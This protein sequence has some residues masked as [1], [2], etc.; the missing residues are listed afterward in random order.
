MIITR[1]LFSVIL[2]SMTSIS[3]AQLVDIIVEEYG[4]STGEY[5]AGHTTYRVYA[6]LE[7]PE[8]FLSAV[9]GIGESPSDPDHTLII[10]DNYNFPGSTT[11]WNSALGGVSGPAVNAAFCA[12]FPEVCYDSFLTI[13]RENS[14]SPG[15]PINVLTNPTGGFNPTFASANEIGTPN[16][17]DDGAWFALAGDPNG[18]PTGPDN[19][20]LI[21]Q[22]T[23]P[24]AQLEFQISIQLFDNG[25]GNTPLMYCHTNE[26][27]PGLIGG[28]PEIGACVLSYPMD[29]ACDWGMIPGCLD[30]L[31]CNFNPTAIVDD[32]SCLFP[33]CNDPEALNYN[34]NAGCDD[35]SCEYIIP[36]CIYPLASNYDPEANQNDGSCLFNGCTDPE[37]N[38][39]NPIANHNDGSCDYYVF[40]LGDLNQDNLI[41]VGDM[42]VMIGSFGSTCP[43]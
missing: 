37:A 24:T 32:G 18:Y 21:M 3:N 14:T 1:Q 13:G 36:G 12:I 17:V 33:G 5:P 25:N 29:G 30:P 26:D 35:G 42:L 38:N 10:C 4:Q 31:A 43:E 9:Y 11:C 6:R 23:C 34:P 20:I 16:P 28:E 22:V 39:Y 15:N 7:D 2:I 40:C 41:N 19:R 8:D 27:P